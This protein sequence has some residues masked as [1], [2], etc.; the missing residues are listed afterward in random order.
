M[1]CFV[2]LILNVSQVEHETLRTSR[3]LLFPLQRTLRYYTN[4]IKSTCDFFDDIDENLMRVAE[5][6]SLKEWEKCVS[7]IINEVHIKEY[8]VYDKHT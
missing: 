7:L 5:Y 8:L 6:S 3:V 4:Y 1:T 2:H